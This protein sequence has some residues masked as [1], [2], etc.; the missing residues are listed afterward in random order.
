MRV[1]EVDTNQASIL[2]VD[3]M[4]NN[5]RLLANILGEEGYN[6]RTL[7]DGRLVMPS[8]LNMRPD[9][10]LLD[11]R[12]PELD[13][14]EICS[15][16]KGDERTSD[17]PII[18]IS[19]L[20][21]MDDK[22]KGFA[23]GCVDYI[24]KPF[25]EDEV[26]ARVKTHL[27]LESLKRGLQQTILEQQKAE[28]RLTY[29]AHH[30][31]LTGL[32]NR[33]RFTANLEQALQAAKRRQCKVAL[34]FL[35]LDRFKIINDTLGHT[36]GDRLLQVVAERL[37]SCVRGEDTVARLGG[38][39]FTIILA[40]V[41]KGHD[42][43]VISD[44]VINSLSEPITIDAETLTTSTSIGI[45]IYPDHADNSED[46]L[47]AADAAMYFA[48]EQGRGNAQFYTAELIVRATEHLKLERGL[49]EALEQGQF[50]LYYQPQLTL[51]DRKIV[52]VEA[53]IRW[54]HPERGLLL[55]DQ[56]IDMADLLGLLDPICDWVLHRAFTDIEQWQMLGLPAVRLSINV[57]GRQFSSERSFNRLYSALEKQ[58]LIPNTLQLDLE[59][60]E[61]TLGI[62]EG[63]LEQIEHLRKL[64]VMFAIDDFGT[65]HS[66]LSRLRQLPI[67]VIKIDRSFINGLSRNAD[68][69]AITSAIIAMGHSFNIRVVAEGVETETQLSFLLEHECDEVQGYLFSEAVPAERIEAMLSAG[70]LQPGD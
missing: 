10:I 69:Q 12:M 42:A 1:A 28:E 20:Q 4:P 70:T 13:G 11:I 3:D 57:S 53:L 68:D 40:E 64:G 43:S 23:L 25:Q 61:D 5:L 60:T 55:P 33:L 7:R 16:L 19:A 18:F 58:P 26:L 36:V 8:V 66:S 45:S 37:K 29:L 41:S 15:Q 39:E 52:G 24:T 34:L 67:D 46:L 51:P 59:I 17:I 32:V 31:T 48:K 62:I 14:F 6:V 9:L 35:D 65:G 50:I 21:D 27:T 22:V 54:Q 49:R 56:F 63:S 2:A 47:R 44:K 38:D 30:D